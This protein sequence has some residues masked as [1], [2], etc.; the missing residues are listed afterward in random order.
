MNKKKNIEVSADQSVGNAT[1]WA[2]AVAEQLPVF[3][4]FR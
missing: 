3:A 4:S 1:A 2:S